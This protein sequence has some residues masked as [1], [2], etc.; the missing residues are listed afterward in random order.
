MSVDYAKA[1]RELGAQTAFEKE[2]FLGA[3]WTGAKAI[4][5]GLKSLAGRGGI[6]ITKAVEPFS[7]GT[8]KL[9][10]G[11]G[12]GAT[13]DMLGFGT[14]GAGM[15]ALANPE[16]RMGGA[17]K[18]FAG[19]AMGGLGWRA[20]GNLLR[21]GQ[22]AAFSKALTPDKYKSLYKT[23]SRQLFTPK[24]KDLPKGTKGPSLM[25]RANFMGPNATMTGTQALQTVG[26]RAALGALPLTAAFAGS[27]LLGA[28]FHDTANAGMQGMRPQQY[29]QQQYQQPQ[30]QQQFY[31]PRQNYG[32]GYP[33]S[34]YVGGGYTGGGS[35]GSVGGY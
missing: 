30:Q 12:K 11:A 25:E 4:G 10:R 13:K 15:G 22:R 1:A 20:G 16:D 31:Q 18:G 2:A 26:T 34:G 21:R 7:A 33:G 14:F 9:L 3:L 5:S 23:K 29:Q 35:Y 28:P 32:N 17:L 19:G 24:V 6:G 8:A 27:D